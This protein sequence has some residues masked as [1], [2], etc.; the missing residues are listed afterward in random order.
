MPVHPI[1]LLDAI[2]FR[3]KRREQ[4]RSCENVVIPKSAQNAYPQLGPKN[5]IYLPRISQDGF[6]HVENLSLSQI[7]EMSGEYDCSFAPSIT[8]LVIVFSHT[9]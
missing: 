9:W 6:C 5:G 8:A 3:G 2:A 1:I 4:S 7:G